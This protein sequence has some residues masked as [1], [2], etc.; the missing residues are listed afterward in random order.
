MIK[1]YLVIKVLYTMIKCDTKYIIE[2]SDSN[3]KLIIIEK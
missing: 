2:L 3:S 1:T